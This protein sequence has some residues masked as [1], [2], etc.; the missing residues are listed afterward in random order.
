MNA[1]ESALGL[2]FVAHDFSIKKK[3]QKILLVGH[4]L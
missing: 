4:I 2:G 1:Q 3:G